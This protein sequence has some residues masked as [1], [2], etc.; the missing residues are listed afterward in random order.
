MRDLLSRE[1]RIRR[2]LKD[3]SQINRMIS[4]GRMELEEA[5]MLWKGESCMHL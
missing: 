3:V 1:F 4:L 2:Y 5:L